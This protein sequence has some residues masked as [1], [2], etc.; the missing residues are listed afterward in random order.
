MRAVQ[1]ALVL[2][3]LE[4]DPPSA[5]GVPELAAG[6]P[7]ELAFWERARAWSTAFAAPAEDAPYAERYAPLGVT[8]A[9][10]SYAADGP[11][12]LRRA[13]VEGEKAGAAEIEELSHHG[14]SPVVNGWTVGM[15]LRV[16]RRGGG[17]SDGGRGDRRRS[18]SPSAWR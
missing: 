17:L 16:P 3:P 6:V 13:L 18:R 2:E 9:A 11:E 12:E 7:D 1:D 8:D 14:S 15:Q 5:V 4:G 10:G